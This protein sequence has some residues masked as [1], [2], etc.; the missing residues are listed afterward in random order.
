MNSLPALIPED[1]YFIFF[2]PNWKVLFLIINFLK[3]YCYKRKI[4]LPNL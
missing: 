2:V 3:E 1:L 4:T